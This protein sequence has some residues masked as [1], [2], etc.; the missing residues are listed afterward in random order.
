[1]LGRY[2]I[3]D[4]L[5]W[6]DK[7]SMMEEHAGVVCLYGIP[8]QNAPKRH[9]GLV[10]SHSVVGMAAAVKVRMRNSCVLRVCCTLSEAS[11]F[12]GILRSE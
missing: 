4:T 11:L 6:Y 3:N 7:D 1:M 12:S 5:G 9:G 8:Y 10:C 2:A